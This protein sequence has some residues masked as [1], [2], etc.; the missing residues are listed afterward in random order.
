[1]TKQRILITKNSLTPRHASPAGGDGIG[2][3]AG[4]DMEGERGLHR[5]HISAESRSTLGQTSISSRSDLG[6]ISDLG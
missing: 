1:M 6:L 2:S 5:G 3:A 4:L